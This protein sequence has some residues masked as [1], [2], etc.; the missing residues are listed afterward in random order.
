MFYNLLIE[1]AKKYGICKNV[2]GAIILNDDKVLIL[3]RKIDD[4]MGGIDELPSGNM[5]ENEGIYDAL[6]REVKEETNLDTESVISYINSFDY[7]SSSNKRVRQ[8]NFVIKVKSLDNIK[9]SEHDAYKWLSFDEIKKS[10]KITDEV[11]LAI[12][13]YKFNFINN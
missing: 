3:S 6:V 4:F 13:I 7:I 8:Y 9:L 11:K 5:E 2:V 10:S 12:E 1:S